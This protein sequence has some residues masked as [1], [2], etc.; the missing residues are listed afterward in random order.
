MD[1]ASAVG[2]LIMIFTAL[3]TYQ[4][5][6]NREFFERYVF[7]VD[8]I[9]I[10]KDYYRLIS[11]GFLHANWWHFGFNMIALLSFSKTLEL[12]FGYGRLS[13]IYFVS[14]LGGSF[15]ALYIHRNHGDYRAVGAS[16]AISGVVFSSIILFPDSK[17][18]FFLLP[19]EITSW[20]FGLFFILISIF[21]I[22]SQRDNIGH[23]AHLGGA[24]TGI[25]V[26]ILLE[27]AVLQTHWL[28]IM[29]LALPTVAFLILIVRNPAVLLVDKYWGFQK[30]NWTSNRPRK[31]KRPSLSK[32]QELD[33]L[34]DK[35][36][37]KGFASLTPK[38][39]QR[40]NELRDT[41]K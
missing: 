36:R 4:G 25:L 8:A 1:N 18:T 31:P 26:T 13:L 38:E 37:T 41:L 9:L 34:L 24:L 6:K 40:L 17:I 16:G 14:M 3:S 10:D 32:E 12:L 11:S 22:K 23:E 2:T 7:D 33:Q 28:I 21:G 5:F 20:V 29:A 35:I 19:I 39:K 15:L 30:P 27:P